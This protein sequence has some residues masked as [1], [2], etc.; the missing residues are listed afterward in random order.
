[1]VQNLLSFARQSPP[2]H[3]PLQIN[4]RGALQ[5]RAYEFS[6]QRHRG[7]GAIRRSASMAGRR[8]ASLQQVFLNVLNNAY[9]AVRRQRDSRVFDLAARRWKW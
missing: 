8:H 3:E 4:K 1:M 9:D 5:L 2:Q 7:G 6:S